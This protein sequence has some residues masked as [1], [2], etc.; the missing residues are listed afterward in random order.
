MIPERKRYIMELQL[1][2]NVSAVDYDLTNFDEVCRFFE[3]N[4]K[5]L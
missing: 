2:K 1:V 3:D 4:N 5:G